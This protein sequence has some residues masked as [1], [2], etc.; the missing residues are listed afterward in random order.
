[1]RMDVGC[2][3]LDTP[4]DILSQLDLLLGYKRRRCYR[5]RPAAPSFAFLLRGGRVSEYY[6]VGVGVRGVRQR[7][8]HQ[9]TRM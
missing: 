3:S 9:A 7:L 5:S 4:N 1:M 6:N 2:M 8:G